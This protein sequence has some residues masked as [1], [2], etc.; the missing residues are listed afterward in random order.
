MATW[1]ILECRPGGTF[2]IRCSGDAAGQGVDP[3]PIG[4]S[5]TSGDG[6][7][8]YGFLQGFHEMF[9]DWGLLLADVKPRNPQI[10][11]YNPK[12]LLSKA[13]LNLL[14]SSWS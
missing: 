9:H 1:N 4:V 6:P 8:K 10:R 11:F 5:S 2:S 13:R 12:V 3:P 14:F 7:R